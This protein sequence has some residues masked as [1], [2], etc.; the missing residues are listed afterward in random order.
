M[1]VLKGLKC[2]PTSFGLSMTC[3]FS[4]LCYFSH[5][6]PCSLHTSHIGSPAP[7]G[8]C[9]CHFRFLY[10]SVPN[11][12]MTPSFTF[13]NIT[14]LRPFLDTQSNITSLPSHHIL[15]ATH[16]CFITGLMSYHE[17]TVYFAYLF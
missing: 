17:C 4:V 6:L 8:L 15:L 3:L 16:P 2:F 14:L 5:T 1:P 12:H 11:V 9:I 13:S 7:R 10:S